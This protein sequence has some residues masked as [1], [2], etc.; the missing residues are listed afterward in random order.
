MR[1]ILDY[2][3]PYRH[4]RSVVLQNEQAVGTKGIFVAARDEEK[5][6]NIESCLRSRARLTWVIV[7]LVLAE[8]L[9]S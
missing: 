6:C 9:R 5:V 1:V 4:I 2:I 3:R 7:T 8:V